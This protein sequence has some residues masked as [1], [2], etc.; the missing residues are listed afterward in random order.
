MNKLEFPISIEHSSELLKICSEHQGSKL[1]DDALEMLKHWYRQTFTKPSETLQRLINTD[2]AKWDDIIA[3][4]RA[5]THDWYYFIA[6]KIDNDNMASF[7]LENKYYP[8]FMTML[9]KIRDIQ[10]FDDATAAV[11]ENIDDEYEPMPHA[12]LMRKLMTAVKARA[13]NSV[14][15]QDYAELNDR[16]II[17]YYGYYLDPWHLVGSLF[18]TEQMGTHR[19]TQ[20]KKGLVRMGFTEDEIEFT[21]VHSEC[22]EHH[23]EDWLERVIVPT[24]KKRPELLASIAAGVAECL[25]TSAD[26]LDFVYQRAQMR[27]AG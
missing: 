16:T 22:D 1:P 5:H 8:T 24:V 17:F 3:T 14:D 13:K 7:M 20:M 4:H 10:I 11:Q 27:M 6:D 9:E 19:V 21:T 18:S 2:P 25:D 23:A 26:Y 15:L 12:E